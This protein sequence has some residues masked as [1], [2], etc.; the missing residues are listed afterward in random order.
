LGQQA[1][2]RLI[3]S[4]KTLEFRLVV[5]DFLLK[6]YSIYSKCSSIRSRGRGDKGIELTFETGNWFGGHL[7]DVGEVSSH[8]L[9][10]IA[11]I[12]PGLNE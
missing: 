2:S 10:V 3:N 4:S 11:Q 6:L 5:V 9:I 7:E 12:Q 8:S 1:H